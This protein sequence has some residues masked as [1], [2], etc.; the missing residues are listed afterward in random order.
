MKQS[1]KNNRHGMNSNS[2]V[3][4]RT[5][6][7]DVIK[8][9]SAFCVVWIHFGSAWASPITTCAV[10]TF[11]VISGFYYPLM[12]KSGFFLETHSKVVDYGVMGICYI[13]NV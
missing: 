9:L 2:I 6:S 11:F 13:W 10:P 5:S 8:C 3:S 7:L 4:S 1:V 12:V